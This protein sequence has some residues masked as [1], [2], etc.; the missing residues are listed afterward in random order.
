MEIFIIVLAFFVIAFVFMGLGLH[1][2]KYK[3]GKKCTCGHTDGYCDK[4]HI[5]QKHISC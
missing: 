5:P 2:S 4:D 1:F 3:K